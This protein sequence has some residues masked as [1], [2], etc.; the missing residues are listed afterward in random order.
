VSKVDI[1]E[2]WAVRYSVTS[3]RLGLQDVALHPE[4]R[5]AYLRW[6]GSTV[7][8]TIPQ[9]TLEVL[10][11][12]LPPYITATVPFSGQTDVA[13]NQPIQVVFDED[14]DGPT[15]AGTV[16]PPLGTIASWTDARTLLL[17]HGGLSECAQ[18]TVHITSGQDLDGDP[19]VSGP[20]PNPWSFSTVCPPFIRYTITRLPEVGDVYV[21]GVLYAAPAT[22]YW[23]EDEVHRIVAVDLDP[24]G[25]SRLAFLSWDDGGGIDHP[26]TVGS[27]DRTITALYGL[28][29][30]VTLTLVGLSGAWPATIE[31]TLFGTTSWEPQP[32]SFSSWVDDGSSVDVEDVIPG[33]VGERFITRDPVAWVVTAP[34]AAE[35]RYLHQFTASV[36]VEGLDGV[37]VDLD[38]TSFERAERATVSDS[39][40]WGAWVD[41][42]SAVIV[43][44]LL[45]V[46]PRE[47]F[48]S[49]DVTEWRVDAPLDAT[50]A[51]LHQFQPRVILNGTDAQH[52]VAATWQLDRAPGGKDGL[53]AEWFAWADAGTT[54]AFDEIT[55]GKPPRATIDPTTFGVDSAFDA[56]INYIAPAPPAPPLPDPNWKPL[57]AFVYAVLLLLAGV[58]AGSR[59][60]DRHVP[61][62]LDGSLEKR[63]AEFENLS[64]PEKLDRLSIA[65]IEE[66]VTYDRRYTR[67]VLAVPFALAEIGIGLLSLSTGIFRIPEQGS[68][69]P[70]GF[71]ANTAVLSVGIVVDLVVRRRGYRMSEDELLAIAEAR[72]RESGTAKEP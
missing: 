39:A 48:Q 71:W 50:V 70:L 37:A 9:G 66:K 44:E 42:A 41:A 34:L 49:R 68:W 19:L 32:A 23:R 30:P 45:A 7:Y 14:M 1:N 55:T 12:P 11:P 61:E 36:R 28:Q 22:F 65:E 43:P 3:T 27:V 13:L 33:I 4:S 59:A 10:A 29:H 5:V 17:N 38:F 35:V 40:A 26:F 8:Q 72:G 52:T 6:D 21:D 56:V 58:I 67:V 54:L 18:Y 46:G 20:V 64:L 25:A 47:R 15:V 62:P 24:F 16:S 31:S 2:T 69:L 57:L 51:Y 53:S 60:L 63:K